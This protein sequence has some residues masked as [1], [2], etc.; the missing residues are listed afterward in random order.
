MCNLAVAKPGTKRYEKF[1]KKYGE[2]PIC[3]QY[4]RIPYEEIKFFRYANYVSKIGA[5]CFL[6]AFILL[7][8]IGK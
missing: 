7:K 2:N 4:M 5:I 8:I 6:F 1:R 3:R